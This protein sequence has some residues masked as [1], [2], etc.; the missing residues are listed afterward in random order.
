MGFL[1]SI[2]SGISS[3][4]GGIGGAIGGALGAISPVIG[5]VIGAIN[6]VA[7]VAGGIMK[8]FGWMPDEDEDEFGDRVI[9]AGKEGI[10]PEKFDKFE[11]Y[12][13]AIKNFELDPEK[14]KET[15]E[16]E[17]LLATIAYATTGL[18]E[19][20]DNADPDN[21]AN[22]WALVA[23][24]ADYFSSDRINSIL[25]KTTDI[26]SVADYFDGNLDEKM[27]DRVE[28][29]LV[30]AEKALSPEKSEDQILQA[31]DEMADRFQKQE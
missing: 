10:T 14:S 19:K 29:R 31:I 18:A 6:A 25:S 13:E 4:A 28:Q 3:V 11:D 21:L 20:Y 7:S 16:Q 8:S 27:I 15:T 9:Q 2:V 30:D 5:V 24:D 26:K 12:A 1:S 17:K 23:E 22:I